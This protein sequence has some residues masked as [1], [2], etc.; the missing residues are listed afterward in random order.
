MVIFFVI[1]VAAKDCLYFIVNRVVHKTSPK[2]DHI[3]VVEYF[4]SRSLQEFLSS[5]LL[6]LTSF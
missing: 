2:S 4:F 1:S 5:V 6:V 3:K